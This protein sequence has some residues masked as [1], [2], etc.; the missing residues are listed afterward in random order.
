MTRFAA[1]ALICVTGAACAASTSGDSALTLQAQIAL[2]AVRGRIDHLA[3]DSGRERLFI[4]ELG[5]GSV[6]VVDLRAQTIVRRLMGFHEPQGVAYSAAADTLYVA[7]AGDGSVRVLR[8]KDLSAVR[9]VR[10]GD[11]AD[12][13]RID[14]AAH[15]VYVGYGGGAIAVIDS[16]TGRRLPDIGLK[17]HPES[18]Q[19]APESPL[20]YVNVPDSGEI[21][22]VD[23]WASRQIAAWPT[24]T[25]AGNFPLALDEANHRVL[26]T[27][28]R[29]PVVSAFDASSGRP[30]AS[31]ATCADADELFVDG[32]RRRLYVICGEG[33]IDVLVESLSTYRRTER[34]PTA[35]GA[36]TGLLDSSRRHL[37]L[38]VPAHGATPAGVR[39]YGVVDTAR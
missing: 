1:L 36:R 25:L 37:Y 19:L 34:V 13:I 27:F 5:N 23:L 30:L 35:P 12:N 31:I 26:V 32:E 9:T 20:A 10:L 33:F 21:A 2:G 38:A 22:V 16:S 29:P 18:F 6:A 7:N 15:R 11:D 17:G 8:G 39:V 4:A 14:A 28:R 3:I 24:G